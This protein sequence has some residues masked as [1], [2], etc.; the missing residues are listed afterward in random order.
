MPKPYF[1]HRGINR[2]RDQPDPNNGWFSVHRTRWLLLHPGD[3]VLQAYLLGKFFC[4]GPRELF[5]CGTC[6]QLKPFDRM[7]PSKY[8]RGKCYRTWCKD[9]SAHYATPHPKTREEISKAQ[10][11]AAIKV[12]DRRGRPTD[13]LNN[14]D[15][16][17]RLPK[18]KVLPSTYPIWE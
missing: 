15:Y 11:E 7:R 12:W 2:K 9:C 5:E 17:E 18:R 1:K 10:S 8:I 14:Y 4:P 13:R 6:G 16:R 3:L